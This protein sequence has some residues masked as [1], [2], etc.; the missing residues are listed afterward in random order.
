MIFFFSLR[1]INYFPNNV[2]EAFVNGK[3]WGVVTPPAGRD[4]LKLHWLHRAAG[5]LQRVRQ[6]QGRFHQL[7][8]PGQL[9]EDHGLHAHG[10]GADRAEPADQHEL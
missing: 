7:Q 2:F 10:D 5:R 1:K 9:H 3:F 4:Q 6:G 8:G